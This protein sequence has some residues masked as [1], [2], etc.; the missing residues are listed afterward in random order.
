MLEY[1]VWTL[2]THSCAY[3][4][5]AKTLQ[6]VH[7]LISSIRNFTAEMAVLLCFAPACPTLYFFCTG[8]YRRG[9]EVHAFLDHS[10][11]LHEGISVTHL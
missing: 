9:L 4:Q 5:F 10:F 7:K 6:L 1:S 11:Y 3:R 8:S 2:C